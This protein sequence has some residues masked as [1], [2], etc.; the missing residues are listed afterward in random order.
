MA[1]PGTF[2]K[3]TTG[4]PN[5]R[6]KLTPDA[7]DARAL[8]RKYTKEAVDGLLDLARNAEESGV[9]ARCWESIL[10]RGHGKAPTVLAG[11]GGVGPSEITIRLAS[12]L[13]EIKT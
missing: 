6:P 12:P 5:G 9:R 10:D 1:R 13:P 4:N 2:P 8:A 7:L 11:E 3:G